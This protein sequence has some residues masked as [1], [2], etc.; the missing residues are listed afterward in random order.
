MAAYAATVTSAMRHAVKIDMVAGVNMYAGKIDL[1]NY[2]TT[3]AAITG[4]SGKF[5]SV[6]AVIAST[7]DEGYILEWIAAS[8]SFKAYRFDYNNAADGPAIEAPTDT[9]I[10]AADFIAIGYK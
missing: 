9:D 8:N 3:L 2:N 4:I 10:G 6:I 1:T 5:R 7:T